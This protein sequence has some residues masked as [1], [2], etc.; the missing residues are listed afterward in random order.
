MIARMYRENHY[1]IDTHTAVA[2]HVLEQYRKKTGDNALTIVAST[3]SPF[4]F[5]NSVLN[6]LGETELEAGTKIL[7]QLSDR[8]GV[9]VPTPLDRLEGKPAGMER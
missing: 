3:A 7:Q 1:L 2:F 6:A 5:C 8:T 9:P 4:K